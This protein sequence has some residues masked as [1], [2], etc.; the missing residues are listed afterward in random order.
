MERSLFYSLVMLLAIFSQ[1]KPYTIDSQGIT[2]QVTWLEGNQMPMVTE[3]GKPD[4]KSTPKPIKRSVRVYPLVKIQELKMEDGLFAPIAEKPLKEVETD[5][6]GR[7][8]ISL[9][10]GRYSVFIV[11]AGGLFANS[12]DSE[13]NVQP[14]TVKSGEWTI[15]DVVVNYA[16]FF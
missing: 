15:V 7:Y 13:G 2:G 16:A 6:N 5:E 10:P 1:C 8:S 14:V 9:S 3:D 12:F 4:V 11:E